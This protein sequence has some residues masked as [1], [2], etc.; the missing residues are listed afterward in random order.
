MKTTEKASRKNGSRWY[1]KDGYGDTD[2]EAEESIKKPILKRWQ[3][4]CMGVKLSHRLVTG[5]NKKLESEEGKME[6]KR[7]EVELKKEK[8]SKK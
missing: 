3:S 2:T 7:A 8:L 6:L 5:R 1:E 4:I